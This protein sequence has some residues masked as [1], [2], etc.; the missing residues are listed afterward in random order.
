MKGRGWHTY[1]SR[2][3]AVNRSADQLH[4]LASGGSIHFTLATTSDHSLQRCRGDTSYKL[5]KLHFTLNNALPA[6]LE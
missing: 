6:F 5:G 1:S 2:T 4:R 3:N